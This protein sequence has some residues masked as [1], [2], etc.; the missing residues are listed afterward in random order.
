MYQRMERAMEAVERV[1]KNISDS[2]LP[3]KKV[4]YI[5]LVSLC[6]RFGWFAFDDQEYVQHR[7][8]AMGSPLSAVMAS[9][10]MESLE[11]DSLLRVMGDDSSWFRYVD[12]VL[13]IMPTNT[14]VKDK[15]RRLNK[16]NKYIQFTVEE[17]VN[18]AL[19]F[20][21]IIFHATT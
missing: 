5:K 6:V 20:L 10:Y 7:G 18:N 19:P 8:L 15:L 12:D 3:V 2:V 4:D 21:F 14:D 17:E 1:I 13:V 11:N 16:V 9:L